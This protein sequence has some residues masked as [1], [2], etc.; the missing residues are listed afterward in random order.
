MTP[1]A[2]SAPLIG[3]TGYAQ[4]GK[5][6]AA[7]ALIADG[8]ARVAFAD[9]LKQFALALNP[10]VPIRL[11]DGAPAYVPLRGLID[12][13]GW[14]V[15]KVRYLEVRS[16]LQRLGTEAGRVVLGQDVWVSAAMA[17]VGARLADA[18]GV[19]VTDCRFP[20]EAAAI[21]AAG[22]VLIRV[23]RPGVGQ[24]NGHVSES[25]LDDDRGD[26]ELVNDADVPALHNQ[27]RVLGRTV[28][29]RAHLLT[30]PRR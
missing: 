27:M 1:T 29:A 30:T 20:N 17:R 7:A 10:I 11:P 23:T 19:I 6:T 5:D 14:D 4:A 28:G 24:V 13:H 12:E 8:W 22:G 16:L 21:R 25:V 15:A 3:L 2:P 26:Y 9:A 18:P